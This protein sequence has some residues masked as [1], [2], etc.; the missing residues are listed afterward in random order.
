MSKKGTGI[1][2]SIFFLAGSAQAQHAQLFLVAGQSNCV[3][4][5]NA[6][7][8][9]S[10]DSIPAYEYHAD[11]DEIVSLKDPTGE[12]YLGFQQART[13]SAWPA[14]ARQYHHLTGDAVFITQAG[15]DGSSCNRKAELPGDGTWDRQGNRLLFHHAVM[16]TKMAEQKTG[17]Q[18]SGIIWIQGERDA[19]AINSHQL[20]K[21]EYENTLEDLI[22][23]FH[24]ALGESVP[25][26]IVQT[27][28]YVGHPLRG[29]K[30]VR[31]VQQQVA[32]KRNSVFLAYT[33]TRKFPALNWM[34]DD[35]IHYI[36]PAY[37]DLG[38]AL[39][40]YIFKTGHR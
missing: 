9:V 1:F 25:F 28:A 32:K 6:S 20:T 33:K 34:R 29:Y 37:N 11:G 22:S 21:K 8:S 35:G 16:K 18:L 38:K 5:G 14:F 10:C 17:I 13:G 27:G 36:Q 39:A 23:R 3:G 12:N 4:K 30:I 2:L 40:S 7:L 31:K 19:N 26:Y 24:N 15:R